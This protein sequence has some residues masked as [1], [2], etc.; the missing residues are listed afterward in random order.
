MG[1]T[2]STRLRP[3]GDNFGVAFS[4][5]QPQRLGSITS[6]ELVSRNPSGKAMWTSFFYGFLHL[7]GTQTTLNWKHLCN[8][9]S[10]DVPRSIISIKKTT[11]HT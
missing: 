11:F 7:V 6:L 1:F 4:S 2:P 5:Q 8:N 9:Y 3:E 10:P